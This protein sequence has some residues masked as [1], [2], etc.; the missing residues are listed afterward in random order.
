MSDQ[1]DEQSIVER[2]TERITPKQPEAEAPE[3]KEAEAV[4]PEPEAAPE[5]EEV[6]GILDDSGEPEPEPTPARFKVTV[7]GDNGEDLEQ[8]VDADELRSGYMRQSDY[9][10]K[11]QEVARTKAEL[12]QHIEQ[13]VTK[14]RGDYVQQLQQYQAVVMQ[15]VAPEL[16]NIDWTQL[17]ATDPGQYVALRAKAEKVNQVLH[18]LNQQRQAAEAQAKAESDQRLQQKIVDATDTL[19]RDI[20]GWNHDLY[21]SL[22]TK[23]AKE[24]G[25]KID[26]VGNIVD[27]RQIKVLHDALKYRELQSTKPLAQKKIAEAPKV[28]KPGASPDKAS[29]TRLQEMKA[30]Q[31][32]KKSGS[33]DDAVAAYQAMQSKRR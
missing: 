33:I 12:N 31:Q 13:T 19:K 28:V 20:P 3:P 26:E 14:V 21:N 15:T 10:R 24:Y 27:P 23:S 25:F 11:T 18:A 8:E 16:Q 7:K 17:A 6:E 22:L 1:A 29:V 32:L 5:P 9:T 30:K 2:I 4:A